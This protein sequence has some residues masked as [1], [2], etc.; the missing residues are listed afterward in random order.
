MMAYR[1]VSFFRSGMQCLSSVQN[2]LV[3]LNVN[4]Q[5]SW[6]VS[7]VSHGNGVLGG[8]HGEPL[9]QG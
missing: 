9:Q 8:G 4:P 3:A 2:G 7:V 5:G 1:R 6:G